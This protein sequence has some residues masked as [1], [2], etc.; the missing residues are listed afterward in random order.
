MNRILFRCDAAL[1]IGSGHIFRCRTLARELQRHGAEV[2]FLCRQQEG[3]LIYLL[4]KEFQVLR[5]PNQP[6]STCDGLKGRQLYEAWLGCSQREDAEECLK[7]VSSAGIRNIDWLVVDHYG[8]DAT[9]HSHFKTGFGCNITF[10]ILVIDDLADRYHHAELLLD[11]NFVGAATEQRYQEFVPSHCRQLLGPHYSLLSQEYSHL[12]R[13][14]PRRTDVRRVLV[15]F[16]GVDKENLTGRTIEA[17][18]DPALAHLAVDV[19]LGS[20]SLHRKAV[21]K[22]AAQRPLTTIHS[23]LPSLA[24]L[25]TRADIAI[26]AGGATTWERTCLKL[27]SLVVTI[28]AN[29]KPFAEALD[30]AGYLKVLGDADTV[31]AKRICSELL[32]HISRSSE[33]YE[34][35]GGTLTDGLGAS[36]LAIAMLGPKTPIKLRRAE[37]SDE[38]L[39][40]QWANETLVRKNSFSQEKITTSEHHHWFKESMADPKRLLLIA[41]AEN[42]VPV[43]QI[44]FDQQ[45]MPSSRGIYEAMVDISIDRCARGHRLAAE[46]VLLGLQ[47][48]EQHWGPGTEAVAEVLRSNAAS[49]ACFRRAGFTHEP[50]STIAESSRPIIRWRKLQQNH[51]FM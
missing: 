34:D 50:L 6:L 37:E 30:S 43:G 51:P 16:G 18:R 25:I 29:Q 27:P 13:L 23:S 4:E 44:R 22:Q 12:H 39:L 19:V 14:V 11:Q 31:S 45:L 5:L 15:F 47:A 20:Q 49:N 10:K 9:W 42:G 36:R 28:A 7:A 17:L 48:M 26:G 24:G 38:T 46:I 35:A 8:L 3:D 41:V 40:L 21:E 32:R 2:L 1:T 33:Q